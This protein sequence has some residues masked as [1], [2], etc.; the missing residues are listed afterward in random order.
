MALASALS[1]LAHGR[2]RRDPA[3]GLDRHRPGPVHR[4][5]AADRAGDTVALLHRARA[6]RFRQA[7]CRHPLRDLPQSLRA[8]RRGRLPGLP[9]PDLLALLHPRRALRRLRCKPGASAQEQIATA[10]A[11]VLPAGTPPSTARRIGQFALVLAG[12]VFT[13]GTLLWLLYAGTALPLAVRGSLFLKIG[14]GRCCSPPWRRGGWCASQ[15]R[16]VAQESQA[17]ERAAADGDRR[18]PPHRCAAAERQG[19]GG[20]GQPAKSRFITG[21]SH[22]MRA[23]LNSIWATRSC[24]CARPAAGGVARDVHHRPRRRAPV[25]R[26]TACWSCRASRPA[27]CATEQEAV[28]LEELLD[29]T[30]RM[31]RPLAAARGLAFTYRVEGTL[32]SR[33]RRFQAAAPDRHQSRQQRHQVHRARQRHAERAP[34]ARAGHPQRGRHRSRHRRRGPS[35]HLRSLRTRQP[36]RRSRGHRPGAGHRAPAGGPDGRRYPCRS[37]PG[38]GSSSPCGS[39]CRPWPPP[40]KPAVAAA[41]APLVPHARA[42]GRRPRRAPRGAA[43]SGATGPAVREA[44]EG[45]VLPALRQWRPLVLLDLNLPMPPAGTCAG[46]SAPSQ[47]RRRSSSSR[48]T[49]QNTEEARLLHG[50]LGFV[51]K[52]VREAELLDMVRRALAAPPAQL[53]ARLEPP[54]PA[55][56]PA[57]PPAPDLLR[58]LLQLGASGNAPSKPCWPNWP[59]AAARSAHWAH[60]MLALARSERRGTELHP[61][62]GPAWRRS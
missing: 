6:G 47:H 2:V 57:Q 18:A 42:G 34:P 62:R 35:T 49:R 54:P 51:S 44:G 59:T 16:T 29:D 55:Q 45:A 46:A 4:P 13:F 24:C 26:S 38:A 11:R 25:Q 48:P 20:T 37:A 33:A 27:S 56:P 30:V 10:L 39:T 36:A 12:M 14:A 17:A 31:F 8:G 5:A 43:R 41:A 1:L 32:P 9:R 3:P 19:G 40:R 28:A 22:E 52:P 58:E 23:G 21:M 50:H 53:E 60:R 7:P 15:S 61:R